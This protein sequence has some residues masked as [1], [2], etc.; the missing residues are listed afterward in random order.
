MKRQ[1][2]SLFMTGS[3][4]NSLLTNSKPRKWAEGAL[5][6]NRISAKV[7]IVFM[8]EL[9]DI[10]REVEALSLRLGQTQDCL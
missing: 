3:M 8:L 2:P 7:K 6:Y 1:E 10:R 4:L 5:L 9:L